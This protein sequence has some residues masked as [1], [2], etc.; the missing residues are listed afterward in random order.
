M[1][2]LGEHLITSLGDVT[3]STPE[4]DQ[5]LAY[6]GS[7]WV[8]TTISGV[9]VDAELEAIAGL[10]SAAD[11][12]PYYTGSGTAALATFNALG[13]S[14][15]GAANAGAVRTAVG[16][17]IG[18][19]VQAYDATLAALATYNTNGLLCQTAED[20]F[21][22][23]TLTGTASQIVVTNG[24]GV[25]GNPTLSIPAS[26]NLGSSSSVSSSI[27]FFE[28]TDNGSNYIAVAAPA[29]IA[30]SYVLTLPADDGEADYV[31]STDGSGVTS[32]VEMSAGGGLTEWTAA[33]SAGASSLKFYE[34]TDNG[35]SY[36]ELKAPASLAGNLSWALPTT[37]GTADQCMVLASGG[38]LGWDVRAPSSAS[39]VTLGTNSSLT[40]ERV[41]TG[42][43]NQI[44]ITDGG[45][46]STVTLA[47]PQNI[48]TAATPQFASVVFAD[49]TG[50]TDDSSNELLWL[51]K[52]TNAVNYVEVENAATT[53][54]PIIRAT[55]DDSNVG[56]SFA[57]KGT[58][59]YN[60]T[61]TSSNAATLRLFEDSDNG[62]N[63]AE[64]VAGSSLG[65]NATLTL[66]IL[67]GTL[68][69]VSSNGLNTI[70]RHQAYTTQ[71]SSASVPST[72]GQVGSIVYPFN[73]MNNY[74][75]TPT[76]CTGRDG[77]GISVS[78]DVI[79]LTLIYLPNGNYDN[80]KINVITAD[81]SNTADVEIA[82]YAANASN[83]HRD[84]TSQSLAGSKV[85]DLGTVSNISTTGEKTVTFS[86]TN[87]CGYYW[88]AIRPDNIGTS[89]VLD[90][91]S[92]TDL[93]LW[94]VSS[95]ATA[96][97]V[98]FT[99]SSTTMA[100]DLSNVATASTLAL[101]D[102]LWGAIQCV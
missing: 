82:L 57:V 100:S 68:L 81:A 52:Q 10:T 1:A 71:F 69:G 23:R 40:S 25:S 102:Q 5:V 24:D 26:F 51:Q 66:P 38:Q 12:V 80:A 22:G 50:L 62:T 30:S 87:F 58:G 41:L 56:L 28:D 48:H 63:Y 95:S 42:T 88:L 99:V 47:L 14:I 45:A 46:G 76:G 54:N 3:I 61:A 74:W 7:N 90:A 35:T 16:V 73:G 44:T 29:S 27:T 17:A 6:D 64:I 77:V 49:N 97:T 36:A 11:T 18:S 93:N 70:I 89:L 53:T 33:S 8:N 39:Y 78:N 21:A 101:T 84:P 9:T 79:Y 65:S 4:A 96:P 13:R 60:F 98:G 94:G 86:S 37:A 55:G 91:C 72:A 2:Q 15:V 85:L 31:L 92:G 43:A 83:G 34:D 67:S 20:T 59:T 32:W 75:A 19:D